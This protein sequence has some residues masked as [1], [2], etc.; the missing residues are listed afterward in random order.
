MISNL[1]MQNM[2]LFLKRVSIM[3]FNDLTVDPNIK[4]LTAQTILQA[5]TNHLEIFEKVDDKQF[6]I[7]MV[8]ELLGFTGEKNHID[9]N[10]DI[11]QFFEG[12]R[13]VTIDMLST[14]TKCAIGVISMITCPSKFCTNDTLYLINPDASLHPKCQS[15]LG[16]IIGTLYLT[17]K[18][19]YKQQIVISTF[20]DH[21]LNGLRVNILQQH[22]D[23]REVIV[24][25]FDRGFVESIFIDENV[26]FSSYPKGYMDQH[27]ENM[28]QLMKARFKK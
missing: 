27:M 18:H 21:L 17:N 24:H 12:G 2:N 7:K 13:P 22:Q 3:Y 19:H 11:K 6:V 15:A 14:G 8:N 1:R 26:E 16:E 28:K 9:Y 10:S 5:S 4:E 23:H 25:F 20:S